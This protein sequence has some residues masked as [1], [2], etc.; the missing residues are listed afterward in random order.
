LIRNPVGETD[1]FDDR[2]AYAND[3]LSTVRSRAGSVL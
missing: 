2:H 1:A 3:L